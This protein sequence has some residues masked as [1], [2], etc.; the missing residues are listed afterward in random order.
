MK[1]KDYG[2]NDVKINKSIRIP[3]YKFT[4]IFS[5]FEKIAAVNALFGGNTKRV[6]SKLV[7]K[8]Y[9]GSWGYFWIDDA[10][11][12]L[13]CNLH[14]I[15]TADKRYVY[16][17]VVHELVHIKQHM[18][19][20]KLFEMEDGYV[21]TPTEIEAYRIAVKEAKRIGMTKKEI[22]DY[23]KMEWL[24]AKDFKRLLKVSGVE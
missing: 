4:N 23:L 10:D 24:S 22:V 3:K 11:K 7:V 17:D 8:P 18:K 20:K 19:G 13:V 12:S 16:L 1:R 15:K 14:Y 9:V 5:G 2:P 6:L 21:N